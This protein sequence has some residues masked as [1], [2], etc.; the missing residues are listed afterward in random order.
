VKEFLVDEGTDR[1]YGARH[2]KRAIERCLVF[3]LSNL[4]ATGQVGLGDVVWADL[5]TET[6]K[7]LFTSERAAAVIS[8]VTAGPVRNEEVEEDAYLLQGAEAPLPAAGKEA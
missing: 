6:R 3:P 1:Q 4:I 7:L 2:L 5:D 8:G